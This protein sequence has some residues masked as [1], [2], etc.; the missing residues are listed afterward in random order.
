MLENLPRL[1]S[2]PYK[3]VLVLVVGGMRR[4]IARISSLLIVYQSQ[5]RRIWDVLGICIVASNVVISI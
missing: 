3:T 5:D 2:D 4:P 1:W